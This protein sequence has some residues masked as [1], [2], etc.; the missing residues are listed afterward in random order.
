MF[1]NRIVL[2]AGGSEMRRPWWKYLIA[3]RAIACARQVAVLAGDPVEQD[4]G[5]EHRPL[6][7]RQYHPRDPAPEVDAV[8]VEGAALDRQAAPNPVVHALR[9]LEVVAVVCV[10]VDPQADL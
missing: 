8:E 2:H 9:P 3:S 4:A 1:S 6:V 10:P 7:V 5:A